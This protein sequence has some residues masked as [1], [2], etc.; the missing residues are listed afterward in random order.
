MKLTDKQKEILERYF[1][2]DITEY[3]N[4]NFLSLEQWTNGGV[5]MIIEIDMQEENIITELEKYVDNFDIDEEI[6]LY[7]EGKDYRDNFTITE[8][9]HDFEEW[10]KYVKRCIKELKEVK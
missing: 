9:L 3:S 8:S 5:D 2:V 10:L 6:D 7:R 4:G 1:G